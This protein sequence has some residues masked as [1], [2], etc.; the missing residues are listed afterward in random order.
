MFK[1]R[2]H[3]VVIILVLISVVVIMQVDLGVIP[4][5]KAPLFL[6][7]NVQKINSLASNL[8]QGFLIS[9]LLY[10]MVVYI[11]ERSRAFTTRKIIQPRLDT[12]VQMLGE[13]IAY[14]VFKYQ[15]KANG[16]DDFGGLT[17]GDFSMITEL[18]NEKMDFRYG[19][20]TATTNSVNSTGDITELYHF[21]HERR[22]ILEK[23]DAI[24]SLPIISSESDELLEAL[25]K[26]RDSWFYIGVNEFDNPRAKMFVVENFSR[27]VYEYYT[28]YRIISKYSHVYKVSIAN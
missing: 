20:T 8:A 27:G 16:V 18:T 6:Q 9:T 23:I 12:I 14:F 19:I 22:V 26:L 24:L 10:F 25:A 13:S 2:I 21:V 1:S 15:L 7:A 5:I 11:P 4:L 3:I 28:Y 17:L